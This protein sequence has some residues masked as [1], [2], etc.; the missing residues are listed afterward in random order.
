[1]ARGIVLLA[2]LLATGF[3]NGDCA[4]SHY[5][6]QPSAPSGDD[7]GCTML[8]GARSDGEHIE[9]VADFPSV[10]LP[11]MRQPYLFLRL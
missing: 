7:K 4:E 9:P 11:R 6:S 10:D 8:T 2:S 3:G 5:L 1:V